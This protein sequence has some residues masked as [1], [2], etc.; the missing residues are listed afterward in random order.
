MDL[1][2][3]TILIT[4]IIS[5]LKTLGLSPIR[6]TSETILFS[7]HFSEDLLIFSESFIYN[8]MDATGTI[9]TNISPFYVDIVSNT[10]YFKLHTSDLPKFGPTLT[11]PLVVQICERIH[12]GESKTNLS[13]D[14]GRGIIK[15]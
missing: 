1:E 5:L 7:I 12:I 3:G 14:Y 10:V 13:G 9:N 6:N 11:T 4:D 8:I 2:D 15:R